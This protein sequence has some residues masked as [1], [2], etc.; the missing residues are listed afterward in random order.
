M[1]EFP[2]GKLEPGEQPRQAL[3]RELRE[4]WGLEAAQVRIGGVLEVT[5]HTYP[6]PGP[7]VLLIFFEVH[8]P[9]ERAWRQTL[10]PEDGASIVVLDPHALQKEEFI[11][12]DRPMA[13]S[14]AEGRYGGQGHEGLG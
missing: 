8:A 14:V 9:S 13:S 10:C 1:L 11:E 4:E 3:A 5:R 12:A 7:D 6:S 2:G